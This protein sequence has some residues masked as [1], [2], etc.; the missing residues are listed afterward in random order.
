MQD[1]KLIL[2]LILTNTYRKSGNLS[3]KEKTTRRLIIW[4]GI[5]PIV[6][7]ICWVTFFFGRIFQMEGLADELLSV[8]ISASQIIILVLGVQAVLS[9]TFMSRDNEFL[10]QLPVKPT[11]LFWVKFSV[12][13]VS[14]AL[15][16]AAV[17]L[18]VLL[19]FWGGVSFADG[20]LPWTFF[21]MMPFTVL[22][23][24]IVPLLIVTLL[25]FPIVRLIRFFKTNS[26]AA[27]G[28]CVV[29]FIALF[30]GYMF[31]MGRANFISTNLWVLSDNLKNTVLRLSHFFFY[32]RSLAFAMMNEEFFK[33]FG[34]YLLMLAATAAV[35]IGV[36]SVFFKRAIQSQLED[37]AV[38][39]TRGFDFLNASR[40]KA[41]FLRE[42][43]LLFS[44]T[45]FAFN[46]I[47]SVLLAPLM[48]IIMGVVSGGSATMEIEG[49]LLNKMQSSAFNS[50]LVL[51]SGM[52]VLCGINYT[53]ALAVS[54]EGQAFYINKYTPLT[55]QEI[56]NA[57]LQLAD[58]VGGV[59]IV[60]IAVA[61]PFLYKVTVVDYLLMVGT[62][63]L[64]QNAFNRLC[65]YRDLV[66]PNLNWQSANE[67]LKSSL[68]PMIPVFYGMGCGLIAVALKFFLAIF[69]AKT[70]SA[71]VA[72]VITWAIIIAGGV[73]LKYFNDKRVKKYGAQLFESINEV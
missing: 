49:Q 62:L 14:E 26:L 28:V 61:V 38:L 60:A 9:S 48:I 16:A 19:A 56:I 41:L 5:V 6:F 47:F 57:K 54:R 31:L 35:V 21:V 20:T 13:Y 4:C 12:T 30:I 69:W 67:A 44:D 45:S 33:N 43:K 36:S 50:G 59:G 37:N 1:Y 22:V 65:L 23:S 73:L 66:S 52:M 11:T 2:N 24:P 32:N 25:A 15:L 55:P 51:S 8:L 63:W 7:M 64:Y 40:K 17:L 68:Y 3:K 18:P 42:V 39:K 70:F 53:A 10:Q 29:V 72:G 46:S 58:L 71:V 34:I 27:L